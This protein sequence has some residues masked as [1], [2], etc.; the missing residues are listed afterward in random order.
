MDEEVFDA[1]DDD[2]VV[3][4]NIKIVNESNTDVDLQEV[5]ISSDI[6]QEISDE[7]QYP[8]VI[9][10]G[11]ETKEE[12]EFF[13][14]RINGGKAL[15]LYLNFNNYV[16][17]LGNFELSLNNLLLIRSISNYDLRLYKNNKDY[18]RIN[19]NEPNQLIKFITL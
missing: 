2:S 4:P 11:V 15:P 5:D 18:L 6:N 7:I 9:I 1:F 8:C 3:V 14:K 17:R 10:R 19:L 16:K 12:V 13:L